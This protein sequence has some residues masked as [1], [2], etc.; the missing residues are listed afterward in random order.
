MLSYCFNRRINSIIICDD[1]FKEQF[2]GNLFVHRSLPPLCLSSSSSSLILLFISH[3]PIYLSSSCLS[4]LHSL[5]LSL[6]L[7]L[8]LCLSLSRPLPLSLLLS[9]S[10]SSSASRYLFLYTTFTNSLFTSSPTESPTI[11]MSRE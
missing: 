8:V 11:T 1:K 4:L 10:L 7:S 6:S 9:L 3:P 2:C 5:S